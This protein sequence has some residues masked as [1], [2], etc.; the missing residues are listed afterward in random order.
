[1]RTLI[2]YLYS[3]RRIIAV[4]TL[5]GAVFTVLM[6]LYGVPTEAA[7]YAAL[8][9]GAIILASAIWDILGFVKKRRVLNELQSEILLTLDHLPE[10]DGDI[11]SGYGQLLETLFIEKNALASAADRR[12]V[13]SSDYFAMWAHQ[14][15]TPI[16]AMSLTLQSSDFPEKGEFSEH[17]QRIEQYVEM[18]LCYVHLDNDDSDLVI[19]KHSLDGII[20]QAV[21]K[22]S[23]QFIRRKLTLVYEPLNAEVL[24]DEKLLLFVI[25]QVISNALKYTAS[26]R[27][28]ITLERP[29]EQL[30][31][32]ILL[33]R[34]TGIGIAPEDLPRVFERGFTGNNGRSDKRATGIGLYLCKRICTKLGHTISARSDGSGTE[35]RIDLRSLDVDT[36]E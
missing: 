32:P 3:R 12:F 4:G 14:I 13:D 35:I 33:I 27:I 2:S 1:M 20:K 30:N 34:D 5:I 24:T 25:E 10:A 28:E 36:R 15:K 23:G 21:R 22:F 11:E 19:K 26:G 18:A 17:L 29:A 7:A 9:C 16:T 8:L 6:I 31:A